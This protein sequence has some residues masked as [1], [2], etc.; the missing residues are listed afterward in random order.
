MLEF[1]YITCI[2][3]YFY[4]WWLVFN[5]QNLFRDKD[6]KPGEREHVILRFYKAC[7]WPI[8]WIEQFIKRHIIKKGD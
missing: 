5:D 1:W 8:L 7:G 2:V 6:L 4:G 3:C